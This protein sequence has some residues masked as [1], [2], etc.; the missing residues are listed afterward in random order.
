MVTLNA[1]CGL[2]S[3]GDVRVDLYLMFQLGVRRNP[4]KST[5]NVHATLEALPF[6]AHAFSYVKCSHAL[7]HVN[8][9]KRALAELL[10]VGDVVDLTVPNCVC[11]QIYQILSELFYLHRVIMAVIA[12]HSRP[13]EIVNRIRYL[14]EWP[15]HLGDH[16]WAIKIAGMHLDYIEGFPTQFHIV[17]DSHGRM[18]QHAKEESEPLSR[19]L[20]DDFRMLQRGIRR[21][22]SIP[23]RNIQ[24][25]RIAKTSEL[26]WD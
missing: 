19:V 9:P 11:G 24:L 10:R 21:Q 4:K 8:Q 18:M 2:D 15:Y 23:K 13:I 17:L 22:L 6:R 7:E 20:M 14:A 16:K 26:S 1:G 12:K 5:A 25:V 3:F